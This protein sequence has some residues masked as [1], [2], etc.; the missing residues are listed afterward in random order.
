[1]GDVKISKRKSQQIATGFL[2]ISLV[3][4]IIVLVV[5][6]TGGTSKDSYTSGGD[7]TV[8]VTSLVCTSNVP[9][10]PFFK[11]QGAHNPQHELKI[12]F[13]NDGV[14]KI[15]YSYAGKFSSEELA[16]EEISKMHA[17]YNKYMGGIDVYQEDLYPTFS[18]IGSDGYANLY[19]DK[20]TLTADTAIFAFL[21]GNEY[22]NLKNYSV[23]ALSSIYAEKGFSCQNNK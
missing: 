22:S 7:N 12:I 16:K 18:T 14:D 8:T 11:P 1:M 15:N 6:F 20:S 9:Q 5:I 23:D 17:S 4:I 3:A 13:E 19:L 21:S 10:D 2:L